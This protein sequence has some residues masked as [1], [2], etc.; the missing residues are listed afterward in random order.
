[1]EDGGVGGKREGSDGEDEGE[2]KEDVRIGR[3]R[4]G[5]GIE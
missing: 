4:E 5:R 1:M 2:G 3:E